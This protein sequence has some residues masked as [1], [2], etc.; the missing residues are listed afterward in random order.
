MT[1]RFVK[2]SFDLVQ[3]KRLVGKGLIKLYS[4]LVIDK[5]LLTS[6]LDNYKKRILNKNTR[7]INLTGYVHDGIVYIFIGYEKML[8]CSGISYAMIKKN[9]IELDICIK[10][11]TKKLD[12]VT[13]SRIIG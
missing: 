2:N 3:F 10:Q 8:A 6:K 9:N 11:Y 12:K 4:G 13:I 5:K 7:L 1:A